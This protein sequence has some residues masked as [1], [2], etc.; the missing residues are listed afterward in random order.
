[1]IIEDNKGTW[2]LWNMPTLIING[3]CGEKTVQQ[4]SEIVLSSAFVSAH[5]IRGKDSSFVHV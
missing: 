2:S 4:T 3:K 5:P 1:M